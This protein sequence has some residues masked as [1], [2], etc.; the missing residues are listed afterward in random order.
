MQIFFRRFPLS[1]LLAKTLRVNKIIM[2]S[3]SKFCRSESTLNCRSSHSSIKL[4]HTTWVG[5]KLDR[6]P[7]WRVVMA[8]EWCLNPFNWQIQKSH[9]VRLE[10]NFEIFFNCTVKCY[11]FLGFQIIKQT[12]SRQ[13]LNTKYCEE[14]TLL[15]KMLSQY[16]ILRTLAVTSSV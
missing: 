16:S 8:N 15:N 10:H 2:K 13:K 9:K 5:E 7:D 3:F 11:F 6:N 4:T 12:N 14:R 1:R